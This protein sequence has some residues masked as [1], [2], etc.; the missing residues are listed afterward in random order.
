MKEQ[1]QKWSLWVSETI[2]VKTH[3][4]CRCLPA[5]NMENM[6][7]WN[8]RNEEVLVCSQLPDSPVQ[9]IQQ[10]SPCL[11]YLLRRAPRA[12]GQC[13]SSPASFSATAWEPSWTPRGSYPQTQACVQNEEY[14][15]TDLQEKA[16]QLLLILTADWGNAVREQQNCGAVVVGS[17]HTSANPKDGAAGPDPLITKL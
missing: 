12:G 13:A 6:V 4:I 3:I 5:Q 2:L 1:R 8:G 14:I 17:L 10:H 15:N 7:P 16:T 11:T 9:A